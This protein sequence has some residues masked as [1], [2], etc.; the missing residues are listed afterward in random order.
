MEEMFLVF[1]DNTGKSSD[2]LYIY[3][4]FL[5]KDPS[6]VFGEYWNV[7]PSGQCSREQKYPHESTIDIKI[8]IRLPIL[9]K[10]AQNNGSL[11]MTDVTD[12]ILAL[13]WEDLSLCE[14]YPEYRLI[15]HYGEHIDIIQ[16]KFK[17]KLESY[18]K[19]KT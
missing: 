13:A 14:E 7:I 6:I 12:D 11:S 2:G 18:G 1:V 9:L 4:L 17:K 15:L 19:E 5:A 10:L 3:E 8:E 16:D